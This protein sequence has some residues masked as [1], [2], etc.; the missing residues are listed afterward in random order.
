MALLLQRLIRVAPA[1]VLACQ[2]ASL[3]ANPPASLQACQLVSLLANQ[4]PRPSI[5]NLMVQK[6]DENGIV[7]IKAG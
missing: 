7:K 5:L 3:L 2:L 6:C 1:S 4:R